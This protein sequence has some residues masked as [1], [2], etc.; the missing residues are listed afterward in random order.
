M[1]RSRA[2]ALLRLRSCIHKS[3]PPLPPSPIRTLARAPP[4]HPLSR[5]LSSSL[6]PLP[7]SSATATASASFDPADAS[8]SA[9]SAPAY[10]AASASFD[11]ADAA[12]STSSDSSD[13]G[14]DNLTSLWEEDARD[15]DDVFTPATSDPADDVVDEVMVARVRA[16]VESTPEDQI[17]SA[18][19]DMAV[20]F[21]EP[22]LS[23]V[24]QSAES[25]SAKKLLLLFKSAANNNPA[26]RS[27]A[28]LEIVVDKVAESDEVDKMNAYMLWDLVKEMGTVPGSVNTQVLNKLL[29]MFLKLKKSKIALEVFDM[30]SDLGCTPDG[31]SYYLV[32]EAAGKKSMVDAAWRVC[33]KMIGSCCFPDNK[34]IGDIVT[35]FCKKKKVKEAQL[36]YLAAKEKLQTPIPALNFL[37]GALARNAETINA[38]LELLE[39]YQGESLKDAGMSYAA[40]IHGLCKTNNVKDAKKLLMR[41]VNLGPAPGNAVFNF[42]ITALSKNGEMEGAKGLMRV[43]ENQGIRPDI[44]TYSV[45]MSGY[46]KGGMVDEAMPYFVMRRKST[47]N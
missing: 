4:R 37:I 2:R 5:F 1:L 25:C 20:D 7:D 30:F 10:A 47:Q 15:V 38:A 24:L 11:P 16:V 44:Y 14:E 40:V 46:T 22:F 9:S 8:A 36:V 17:P 12:A 34:K 3:L 42:V 13:D 43:M 41:M 33:E 39:E 21:T 26:A 18:L 27:L 31:D 28:N 32:I 29:A 35:F 23:A 6:E 45:I 19:A